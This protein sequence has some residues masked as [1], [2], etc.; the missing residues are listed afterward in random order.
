ME[1]TGCGGVGP[2]SEIGVP[3]GGVRRRAQIP[4]LYLSPPIAKG[5]GLR[6]LALAVL[7]AAAVLEREA[8]SDAIA[9]L[10]AATHSSTNLA[11]WRVLRSASTVMISS[12]SLSRVLSRNACSVAGRPGE[13]SQKIKI[14]SKAFFKFS[15]E[16]A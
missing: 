14:F 9:A 13:K 1:E 10:I 12:L 2:R 8:A 5:L 7:L 3:G 15:I 4:T 6:R 11:Y 16:V